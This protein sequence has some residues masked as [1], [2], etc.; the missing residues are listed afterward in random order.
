MV[1]P[2]AMSGRWPSRWSHSGHRGA[3]DSFQVRQAAG[4]GAAIKALAPSATR[5][6]LSGSRDARHTPQAEATVPCDGLERAI[7][8]RRVVTGQRPAAIEEISRQVDA[9]V[10]FTVASE[11]LRL[12]ATML[13]LLDG[14]TAHEALQALLQRKD[15]A[16]PAYRRAHVGQTILARIDEDDAPQRDVAV[17]HVQAAVVLHEGR[18]AEVGAMRTRRQMSQGEDERDRQRNF[19]RPS[20]PSPPPQ[21]VQRPKDAVTTSVS[22]YSVSAT[23]LSPRQR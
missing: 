11:A 9:L 18:A 2:R 19:H 23:T 12:D 14:G 3:V 13:V 5:G 15:G 7:V 16:R 6:H 21:P 8:W 4:R 17:A 10:E 22:R 1:A 20:P